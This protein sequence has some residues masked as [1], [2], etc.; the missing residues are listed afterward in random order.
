MPGS[1]SDD[2]PDKI[3]IFLSDDEKIKSI[4]EILT[5]N[6][7]RAIL[8]LLFEEELTANRIAQSTGIS[9]QLVKYHLNKMQEVRMVKVSRI[10]K[11]VKAQDM[12]Y[13]KT[14]KFAI[15]ILPSKVSG[16]ARESKLLMHSFKTIYKFAGIGV[17]AVA[18]LFSLS[19]LQNQ[20]QTQVEEAFNSEE[21]FDSPAQPDA[22]PSVGAESESLEDSPRLEEPLEVAQQEGQAGDVLD[23]SP[24]VSFFDGGEAIL[25]LVI[26][27]IVLGG[28][29]AYLLLR[30]YRRARHQTG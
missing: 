25:A 11:N 24:A 14:T 18:S 20:S 22:A 2:S 15:V 10:G 28:L 19:L 13:Y 7:S 23:S 12:K 27:G 6:S 30:S 16:R 5:N 17:V 3:E 29:A 26:A 1:N 9:L 21:S 4:G 8:Q